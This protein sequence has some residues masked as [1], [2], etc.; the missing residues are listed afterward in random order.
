MPLPRSGAPSPGQPLQVGAEAV[1]RGRVGTAVDESD[2]AASAGPAASAIAAA[3]RIPR[4]MESPFGRNEIGHQSND[5]R[6]R[7]FRRG[8]YWRER[9]G[10]AA[11]AESGAIVRMNGEPPAT[12]GDAGAGT[13][14]TEAAT[15][16]ET[17]R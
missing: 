9:G 2:S 4:S 17:A 15:G 12:A 13:A 14:A 16:A 8:V 3:N 6:F 11:E 5:D 7:Q 10:G 1:G